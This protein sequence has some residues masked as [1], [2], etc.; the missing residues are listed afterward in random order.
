[1]KFTSLLVVAALVLGTAAPAL[2][3]NG[4]K[5]HGGWNNGRGHGHHKQ[6]R[7]IYRQNRGAIHKGQNRAF[8][9]QRAR[10]AVQSRGFNQ[11]G[12]NQRGFNQRGFNQQR[13]QGT[14]AGRAFNQQR[15]ANYTVQ[16]QQA[17]VLEAQRQQMQNGGYNHLLAQPYFQNY[18]GY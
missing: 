12:F 5:R 11:R 15:A 6:I 4:H 1:M 7:P 9:P 13:A 17:A 14:A 3:G 10:G 18:Y 16:Q 2:A 8:I